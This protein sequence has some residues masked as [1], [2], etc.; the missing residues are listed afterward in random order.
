METIVTE[1]GRKEIGKRAMDTW[2]PLRLASESRP[3][4]STL[5]SPFQFLTP[6]QVASGT[7]SPYY[8]LNSAPK[9]DRRFVAWNYGACTSQTS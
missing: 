2:G 4:F 6:P 9:S 8:A 1:D 5:N 3:P 7:E